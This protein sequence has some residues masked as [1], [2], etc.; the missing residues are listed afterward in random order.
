MKNVRKFPG[1]QDDN[2]RFL[3]LYVPNLKTFSL[4]LFKM[5][6]KANMHIG[7]DEILYTFVNQAKPLYLH[8]F[9]M[10]NVF[11]QWD[12]TLDHMVLTNQDLVCSVF[13]SAFGI[14]PRITFSSLH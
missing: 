2:F 9:G 8:C 5:W 13:T 1:V 7:E 10:S 6:K 11:V 3:V 12:H 14:I 4:Q